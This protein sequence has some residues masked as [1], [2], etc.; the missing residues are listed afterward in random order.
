ML[1]PEMTATWRM[2]K[3][4]AILSPIRQLCH[5]QPTSVGSVLL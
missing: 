4:L 5:G 1:H 3:T 2:D